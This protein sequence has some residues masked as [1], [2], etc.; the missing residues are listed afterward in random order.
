MMY[1]REIKQT[2]RCLDKTRQFI[3]AVKDKAQ[4]VFQFDIKQ[5]ADS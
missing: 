2:G 3:A 4:R 1:E 5:G